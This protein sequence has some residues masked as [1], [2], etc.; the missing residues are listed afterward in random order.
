MRYFYESIF[1]RHTHVG[2][3]GSAH[4]VS[5]LMHLLD[6]TGEKK[7][8]ALYR[9]CTKSSEKKKVLMAIGF[10]RHDE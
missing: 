4:L 1:M 6:S 7:T 3:Q 2:L 8:W 5:V 9:K 10:E